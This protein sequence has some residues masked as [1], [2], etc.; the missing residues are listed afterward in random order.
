MLAWGECSL[1]VNARV[2]HT[3]I[4]WKSYENANVKEVRRFISMRS[5]GLVPGSFWAREDRLGVLEEKT[6]S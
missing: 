4:D 1:G 5:S 2:G 6:K 3:G